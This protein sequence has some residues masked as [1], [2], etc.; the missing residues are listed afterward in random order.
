M[1]KDPA[2]PDRFEVVAH[3]VTAAVYERARPIPPRLELLL[4]GGGGWRPLRIVYSRRLHLGGASAACAAD[5]HR[6][7]DWLEGFHTGSDGVVRH[8]RLLACRDCGAV[9]VRDV[10]FDAL[11][12]ARASR[13]APRRRDKIIGWY[14]GARPSQRVYS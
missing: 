2:L 13:L 1:D 7:R 8:L 14:S 11:P 6:L 9:Q 10:S 5:D 4:E 12:G 3:G